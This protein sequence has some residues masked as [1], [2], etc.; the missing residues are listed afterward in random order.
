LRKT[1]DRPGVAARYERVLEPHVL[2]TMRRTF[3]RLNRVMV[4]LWRLGLG[5]LM[6][7]WPEVGGR[8]LV[9]EHVG[10]SS[11]KRYRTPL[12]YAAIGGE[13]YCVAAFGER[14]HWYRNL[15]AAP[16]TAVWLPD[17]RWL[18]HATDVSDEPERIERIR[19]V[20]IASGFV[21]P[22]I[23]LR[24][25]EI[26]D[27]DLDAA[28]AM[29]RVV[30]LAPRAKM[31]V[32]DGPGSLA[33]VWPAVGLVLGALAIVA[34]LLQRPPPSTGGSAARGAT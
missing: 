8:M 33:W 10:R 19:Q 2:E 29:Y 17:G 34:L 18:A 1:V 32:A 7:G 28:T 9:L 27:E 3:N 31:A 13:L 5:R 25:A 21:A 26:S 24:P 22:A 12:D 16:E 20:L 30:R 15:L 14:T 11:G 4:P 6:N 23:G